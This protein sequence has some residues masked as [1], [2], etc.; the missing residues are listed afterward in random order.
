MLWQFRYYKEMNIR[1]SQI[2]FRTDAHKDKTKNFLSSRTVK[3]T[4]LFIISFYLLKCSMD[5]IIY[6]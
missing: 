4:E 3:F 1:I 2:Y 6:F 5:V